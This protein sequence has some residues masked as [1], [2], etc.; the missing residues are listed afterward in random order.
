MKKL[1]FVD[2]CL[3]GDVSRTK[4]LADAFLAALPEGEYATNR[5][6]LG[7]LG[8]LPLETA[9]YFARET[10][11]DAGK[12]GDPLFDLARQFADA[13]LVL[14]AAPFWDMGIPAILKTYIEH[15][16]ISGITFGC[17]DKGNFGGLCK[18]EKMILLTTRGMEIPDGDRMEQASPYLKAVCAFFGIGGFVL[19]S[20][21]GLDVVSAEEAERRLNAAREECAALAAGC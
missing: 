6:A 15:V 8:I 13:D 10:L 17:D 14:V 1:L 12:L 16:S 5:I 4:K 20:A 3:R 2:C 9:R 21:W 11:L 18:A 7:S 19:V